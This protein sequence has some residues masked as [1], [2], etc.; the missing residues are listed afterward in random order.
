[1]K[2]KEEVLALFRDKYAYL[3]SVYPEVGPFDESKLHQK[4]GGGWQIDLENWAAITIRPDADEPH[5]THGAIC[6]RWYQEGG[7]FNNDG[8]PGWLGYPIADTRNTDFHVRPP[9][10]H[11]LRYWEPSQF[12]VPGL[13]AEFEYGRIQWH[14]GLSWER[15]NEH[16]DYDRVEETLY[17]QGAD[18]AYF[19]GRMEDM[20]QALDFMG[21][22]MRARE[23]GR[24]PD[25][26]GLCMSQSNYAVSPQTWVELNE[27]AQLRVPKDIDSAIKG[28]M[29]VRHF[30]PV[31]IKTAWTCALSYESNSLGPV[32]TFRLADKHNAV[33][34]IRI[35]HD[36]AHNILGQLKATPKTFSERIRTFFAGET[37]LQES[38]FIPFSFKASP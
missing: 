17:F 33:L 38:I 37:V 23:A 1:M 21:G 36:A 20:D 3:K 27:V 12:H 34:S 30:H 6:E 15:A 5:E 18:D 22:A 11:F 4:P 10:P 2:T 29:D 24:V 31:K 25:P 28:I 9:C 8:I 13:L 32:W 7:A 16:H 19:D 14:D 26:R 35:W